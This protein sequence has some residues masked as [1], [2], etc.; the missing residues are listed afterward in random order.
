MAAI[1]DLPTEL[2]CAIFRMVQ[3]RDRRPRPSIS[4][5]CYRL[6]LRSLT[7]LSLVCRTWREVILE[8]GVLWTSIPVD[9]SRLDYLESTLIMLRRSNGAEL[10]LSVHLDTDSGGPE[11]AR[12]FVQIFTNLGVRI[13]SLYISIDSRRSFKRRTQPSEAA[14]NVIAAISGI[15]LSK[16]HPAAQYP[17]DLFQGLSTLS[18][19]LPSS[20][21]VVNLSMI[22]DVMKS[23]SGLEYLHL[24]SFFSINEDCP[25]TSAVR[26]SNLL[27]LSLQRCDSA[28][29][30]SHIITPKTSFIDVVMNHRRTHRPF[31]HPHIL[32]AFPDSPTN[33]HALEETTK[34]VL[35]ADESNGEFSLSLSPFYSRI[36]SLVITT[37]SPPS[38]KFIPRSLSAIAVH[39]YFCV[40]QSFTFSCS[41]RVPMSW[42]IVLSRFTLLSELNTSIQHAT[43]V[44]CALMHLRF[45]GSPLC[46]SLGRIRFREQ[47]GGEELRIDPLLFDALR[48]FRAE[49]HCSVIRITLHRPGR[50]REEL[51][52]PL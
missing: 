19:S 14:T 41:S 18:L 32:T 5:L 13:R 17:M 42:P 27:V 49:S 16:P 38:E 30:L 3:A 45:D 6:R 11:C 2:L 35:E 44:A 4:L 1:Q 9:T 47:S 8:C 43:D 15:I 39:P 46:S 24:A 40:I 29:I 31:A 34:L 28:S 26:M 50:R 37:R 33:I 23:C 10:E 25:S 21:V 22:L 20:A 48:Q 52:T 7:P 36:S 51:S 12:S